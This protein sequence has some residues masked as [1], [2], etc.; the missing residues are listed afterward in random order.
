MVDG[1]QLAQQ[2]GDLGAAVAGEVRPHPR[3]QVLGLADVEHASGGVAEQVH[4]RR[5]RQ[6]VGQ[7]DLLEGG[8][9]AG[10]GELD[11]VLEGEHPER[12]GP[13]QQAVEHVHG[14]PGVG[15]RPVAGGH[16]RPEVGGQRG[17]PDVGH[18]VPRQQ[19]AGQPGGAHDPV[20]RT[21]VAVPFQVGLQEA[22]V[23]GGVVAHEHGVAEEFQQARQDRLDRLGPGDHAVADPGERA[24]QRRDR[25]PRADQGLEGADHLAAAHL[26]GA[27][28]GDAVV[29]GR[30]ARGLEVQDHELDLDQ[31]RAEVVEALLDARDQCPSR[32]YCREAK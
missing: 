27:D 16:R 8:V 18:L 11:Q 15:Q 2:V 23:E 17:Q 29:A 6:P 26:D 30:A 19:L 3:A 14:G 4:A 31:R 21:L 20:G 1:G 25:D 7:V 12:A 32:R 13:L 10:R 28:L 9:G 5:V 22:P 24:D